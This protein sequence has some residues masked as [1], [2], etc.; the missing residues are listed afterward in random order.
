[1]I[2]FIQVDKETKRVI[3]YSSTKTNN[4]SNILEIE[5]DDSNKELEELF[6]TPIFYVFNESTNTFTKDVEYQ[7]KLIKEREN[8]LSNNE[9][10]EYLTKQLADE[11][12]SNMKKNQVIKMLTSQQATIM[13]DIMKL[14]GSN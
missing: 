10:I 1:M 11:K 7:N 4:I 2:Y 5:L 13:L 8:R 3:G 14:K 9:K 12:L 6:I